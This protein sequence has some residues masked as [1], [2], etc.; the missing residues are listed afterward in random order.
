MFQEE[1]RNGNIDRALEFA[2][3]QE[4]NGAKL[5][6]VNLGMG[7]V[8]EKELMLRTIEALGNVTNS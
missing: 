7:G 4:N 8:D 3:E 6:D 1:L 2:T 5:L